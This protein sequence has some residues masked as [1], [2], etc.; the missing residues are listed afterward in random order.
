MT[1]GEGAG[2]SIWEDG[3][4][5]P[6]V[7]AR[8]LWEGDVE[9]TADPQSVRYGDGK[10]ART[11]VQAVIAGPA[12]RGLPVVDLLWSEGLRPIYARLTPEQARRVA[13]LLT[14]AADRAAREGEDSASGPRT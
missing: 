14:S 11:I 3:L 6:D 13:D 1:G 2:G 8:V 9:L 5:R 12:H 4:G 7:D 10:P